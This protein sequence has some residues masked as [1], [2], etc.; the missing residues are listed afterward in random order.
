MSDTQKANE[1]FLSLSTAN[2]A[3]EF[4]SRLGGVLESDAEVLMLLNAEQVGILQTA[5]GADEKVVTYLVSKGLI[6]APDGAE[7][8]PLESDDAEPAPPSAL[9]LQLSG[10]DSAES[11]VTTLL[12]ADVSSLRAAEVD[13]IVAKFAS[14]PFFLGFLEANGIRSAEIQGPAAQ[15]AAAAALGQD[16]SLSLADDGS[17]VNSQAELMIYVAGVGF[18]VPPPNSLIRLGAV[19]E[20]TQEL[21]LDE[22][23][24]ADGENEN[25]SS[26]PENGSDTVVYPDGILPGDTPLEDGS[27]KVTVDDAEPSDEKPPESEG[28]VLLPVPEGEIGDREPESFSLA[29]IGIPADPAIGV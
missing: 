15:E 28:S 20:D 6:S 3:D 12:N 16:S 21:A 17:V 13:T 26:S 19:P 11:V 2:G 22:E 9:F 24:A 4:I 8:D 18:V 10:M 14:D 7:D 25:S 29:L 1:I 5:F 27:E 23:D